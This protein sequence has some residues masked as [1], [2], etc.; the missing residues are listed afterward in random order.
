VAEFTLGQ[1]AELTGESI[2]SLRKW[3]GAGLIRDDDPLG[4]EDAEHVRLIRFLLQRGFNL[5]TITRAASQREG[6]LA[7]FANQEFPTGRFPIYTLEEAAEKSGLDVSLVRR[8][9]DAA[10]FRALGD[11]LTDDDVDTLRALGTTLHAGIPEPALIELVRVYADALRR[12]AE[13]EIRLFHF[14]IH[15]R[16]RAAGLSEAELRK[17]DD[18]G[19]EQ[20]RGLIEPAVLYFHHKGWMSAARDDLALHV[21]EAAGISDVSE[22]PGTLSATIV[23]VDL[24]R[25]TPLTE[26]MGDAVA[27]DVV[28]RFSSVVRPAVADCH[29]RVVKQLGDAYMLVFFEPTSAIG[30]A[31]DIEERAAA[32]PQFPAVRAGAHV[33]PV[34][35]RDGDYVG[36]TVNVA[37]RL[38]AE[39]GSHQ[40]L[41]TPELR[42]AAEGT[43]DTEFIPLGTR[44]L[45]GVS[46]SIELYEARRTT[47]GRRDRATDPVCGMEL[48][49]SDIAARLDVGGETLAFCSTDCLQRFVAAPEK[50]EH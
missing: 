47:P 31:L 26:V 44:T 37:S 12:V 24:A 7:D 11:A 28:D 34:L 38:E 10:G 14:H 4:S 29:G 17:I 16:L 20:L 35:Y 30:C 41:V 33:G 45:K 8:F 49:P 19:A 25:F 9:W 1:L 13:A 15:E 42:T 18:A 22:V 21:A 48:Y 6:L 32:E 40:L 43:P 27:A 2:E 36:A 50:Y 5:E 3:R 46:E 39:A 23:F